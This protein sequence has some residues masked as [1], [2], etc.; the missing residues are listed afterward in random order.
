MNNIAFFRTKISHIFFQ[1]TYSVVF[2][3]VVNTTVITQRKCKLPDAGVKCMQIKDLKNSRSDLNVLD[4]T[5][6]LTSNYS[7]FLPTS[8]YILRVLFTVL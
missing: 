5:F 4:V 8:Y 6:E 3:V 7:S 1:E 2:L